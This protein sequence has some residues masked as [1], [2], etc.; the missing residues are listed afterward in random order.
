MSKR[1]GLQVGNHQCVACAAGMSRSGKSI[2]TCASMRVV[3]SLI[4]LACMTCVNSGRQSSWRGY[5]LH[6][7]SLPRQHLR[8]QPHMYSVPV[9]Q[10]APPPV[11][12]ARKGQPTCGCEHGQQLCDRCRHVVLATA[13]RFDLFELQRKHRPGDMN[14][15]PRNST[16][17]LYI[18]LGWHI[19]VISWMAHYLTGLLWW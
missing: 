9:R 5:V 3:I 12:S 14:T 15:A 11:Q 19:H 4:L 6:Y 18:Y 8:K 13:L 1:Y 7:H 16:A 17:F 2:H 10:D